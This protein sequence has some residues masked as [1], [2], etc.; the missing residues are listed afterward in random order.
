MIAALLIALASVP[1][2]PPLPCVPAASDKGA[3]TSSALDEHRALRAALGAPMPDAPAMV[4]LHGKGGHLVTDEYSIIL[5]R[6]AD[7]SWH[8][9]AVGRSQIWV[10]DAPF[11]PMKRA[12]WTLDEAAGKTLDRAI[13]RRCPPTPALPR[14]ATPPG[15]PPRDVIPEKIDVVRRGKSTVSFYAPTGDATIAALI[16]PPQQH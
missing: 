15:P 13:A 6:H 2:A 10:K 12:E 8:G 5:A 4:M 3:L 11:E 9:T 7:A 14:D 16:R 1:G